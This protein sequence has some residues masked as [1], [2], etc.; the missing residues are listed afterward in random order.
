MFRFI[1]PIEY[2]SKY[3]EQKKYFTL[4]ELQKRKSD[5][6]E[7]EVC[8]Q[9]VWKLVGNGLI[10]IITRQALHDLR[11]IKDSSDYSLDLIKTVL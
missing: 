2:L 8:G 6:A 3:P 4:K 1:T 7:C 11:S 9:P 5:N 10:K